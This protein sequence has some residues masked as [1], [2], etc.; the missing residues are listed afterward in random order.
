VCRRLAAL[1]ALALVG[2]AVP[3][4]ALNK[5]TARTPTENQTPVW[6]FS[7]SLFLGG[8]VFNPTYAA[9]PNN[10]G[11]ALFRFGLHADL[12]LYRRYLT[13]SYDLNSFTD[14]SVDSVNPFAP[15]ELDH[16][17][18]LL[19]T[20]PLPHDLA[21]TLAVH[22]EI[23]APAFEPNG[24]FRAAHPDCTNAGTMQPP[25]CYL[26]GY[27]QS[28][29]DAY[30]RLTLERP[31]YM[32]FVA[33]GGFLWN[34]TYAARP[35]NSGI[36]LLRYV[37]HGELYALPWLTLRLDLN[38]F[39]DRDEEPLVPSELDA[40]SEIGVRLGAGFELRLIGE[41]DLNLGR[42]PANGPNPPLPVAGLQQFYLATLLQW[43][44]DLQRW[45]RR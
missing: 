37:L 18:G 6:N 45:L 36:A 40:T 12:D 2:A 13:L 28:Y 42:Y 25:G 34:P 20:I 38:F 14:G 16:I 10:S 7:G 11:R 21:L 3:A 43:S 41:A 27:T 44:F 8:F 19:S 24:R 26:A 33:L 1:L 15:S 22:Y 39:T 35:D 30:G 4:H 23:D 5:Q 9:R 32:A 29:V 17:V 31:R